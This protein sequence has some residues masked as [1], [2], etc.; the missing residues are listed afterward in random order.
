MTKLYQA[1][2]SH[3]SGDFDVR[4]FKSYQIKW[5]QSFKVRPQLKFSEHLRL[6]WSFGSYVLFLAN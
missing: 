1:I 4:V 5:N 6:S 2:R 3:N